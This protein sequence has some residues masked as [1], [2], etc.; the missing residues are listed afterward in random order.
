MESAHPYQ[1]ALR[2]GD[3]RPRATLL[4]VP[5]AKEVPWLSG[6]EFVREHRVG[7]LTLRPGASL[8]SWLRDLLTSP[9]AG[10][11]PFPPT[12]AAGPQPAANGRSPYPR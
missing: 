12:G 1:N 6:F 8:P 9:T 3:E 7:A 5:D 4:L 11:D 2:W 10:F